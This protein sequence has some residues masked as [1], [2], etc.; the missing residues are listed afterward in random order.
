MKQL[1]IE[2]IM[3]IAALVFMIAGFEIQK[4]I[5]YDVGRADQ[6]YEEIMKK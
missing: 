1:K 6:A 4:D 2:L 3:L 5:A